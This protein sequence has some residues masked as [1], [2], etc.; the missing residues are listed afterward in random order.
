MARLGNSMTSRKRTRS[1][2]WFFTWNNPPDGVWAQFDEIF[3]DCQYVVQLE[4]AG[5]PHLQGC[6]RFENPRDG[7][8]AKRFG[9]CHWEKSRW[10]SAVKYCTKVE[11]RIA[12]PWT[13]VEGLSWRAT[14]KSPLFGK[15][16][17]DWQI[18]IL[19]LIKNDPARS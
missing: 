17:F 16:L 7:P 10:P 19:E 11:T 9:L 13:N 18:E 3:D 4:D 6:I 8:G 2:C 5:T 1:R 12:G 14:I 15:E